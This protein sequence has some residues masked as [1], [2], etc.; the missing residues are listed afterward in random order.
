MKRILIA[1]IVAAGVPLS[2]DRITT[3][4]T[5]AT[6]GPLE[7]VAKAFQQESGHQ[8]TI[9]FDTSQ[10]IARRLAGRRAP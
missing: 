6:Q 1:A 8:V 9:Q 3:L 7:Q 5:G 2:A 10:N 4:A